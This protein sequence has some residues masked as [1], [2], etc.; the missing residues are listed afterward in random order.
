MMNREMIIAKDIMSNALQDYIMG[1]GFGDVAELAAAILQG[2]AKKLEVFAAYC[3]DFDGYSVDTWKK[4]LQ[5]KENGLHGEAVQAFVLA[6]L[7]GVAGICV[8]CAGEALEEELYSEY[9]YKGTDVVLKWYEQQEGEKN[10]N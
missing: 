6:V 5:D 2:D 1:S 7:E 8:G 4:A 9:G 10:E 3:D